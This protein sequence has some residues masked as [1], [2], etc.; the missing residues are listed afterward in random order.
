MFLAFIKFIFKET[1]K[2][3]SYNCN[4]KYLF[5]K[6]EVKKSLK[7]VPVGLPRGCVSMISRYS[8]PTHG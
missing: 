1:L 8:C 5:M 2:T 7:Q 4:R 6:E 3:A